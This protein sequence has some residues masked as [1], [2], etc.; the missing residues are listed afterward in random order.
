MQHITRVGSFNVA[1]SQIVACGSFNG[2]PTVCTTCPALP[3]IQ[4]TSAQL[5]TIDTG[6]QSYLRSVNAEQP[7]VSNTRTP[8]RKTTTKA[9]TAGNTGGAPTA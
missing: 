3:V 5:K 4:V 9:R 1:Y 8:A 7:T 2:N 6:W